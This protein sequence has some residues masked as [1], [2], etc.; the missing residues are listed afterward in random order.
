MDVDLTAKCHRRV[1][2]ILAYSI[3]TNGDNVTWD[4]R[5]S[6]LGS[7]ENPGRISVL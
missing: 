4:L 7:Q 3:V 2:L 6:G 5:L 1:E